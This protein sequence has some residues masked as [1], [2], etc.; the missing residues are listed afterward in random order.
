MR[1][2]VEVEPRGKPLKRLYLSLMLWFMGRAVQAAARVDREVRREFEIL[3]EDFTF[4]LGA[5]SGGPR[6]VVSKDDAGVVRSLG[7]KCSGKSIDLA[8]TVKSI[9]ALF[10]LFTFQESTP[11]ANARD[12]LFVDGEVPHACAVV[13]ILD[14]VQVYLLP[15]PVARLAIKRYP[16]WSLK[17]HAVDRT[18]VY[19]RTLAGI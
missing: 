1:D 7:G 4:S 18:L 9:E 14:R 17:R 6:M 19:L 12:R 16:R 5:M 13:R 11:V 10:L 8:M 2:F 15:K 3:P